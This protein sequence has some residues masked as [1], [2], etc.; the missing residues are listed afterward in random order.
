MTASYD[1]APDG[2]EPTHNSDARLAND[3]HDRSS[4][5]QRLGWAGSAAGA[6]E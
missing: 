2:V 3:S 1:S 4:A 5:L 6:P